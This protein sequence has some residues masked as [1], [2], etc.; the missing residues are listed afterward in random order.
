MTVPSVRVEVWRVGRSVRAG[1]SIGRLRVGRS[2][3]IS[4][5]MLSIPPW[6]TQGR[7]CIVPAGDPMDRLTTRAWED[8]FTKTPS[9]IHPK[10][11]YQT[12]I[13]NDVYDVP[14]SILATQRPQLKPKNNNF[15]RPP[16][17]INYP[18]QT[19]NHSSH[20]GG[21]ARQRLLDIFLEDAS[22]RNDRRFV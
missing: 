10:T 15:R 1:R 7:I 4:R 20:G 11:S 12:T 22:T 17:T 19:A 16:L 18:P 13:G 2:N 5:S 6:I 3:W 21:P 14:D 9:E 8:S